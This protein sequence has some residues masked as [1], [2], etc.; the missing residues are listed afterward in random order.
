MRRRFGKGCGGGG[1]GRAFRRIRG[2]GSE[3]E[4]ESER[5][6][7]GGPIG[8]LEAVWNGSSDGGK[9]GSEG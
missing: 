3:P 7:V 5:S 9:G 8:R 2:G 6:G 4:G 1:F